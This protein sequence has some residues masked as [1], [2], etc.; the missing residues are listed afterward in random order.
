MIVGPTARMAF[1]KHSE[2]S[3]PVKPKLI[4]DW[5]IRQTAEIKEF[6]NTKQARADALDDR[7]T[8]ALKQEE[9]RGE[10]SSHEISDHKPEDSPKANC[11]VDY[12]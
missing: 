6:K 2:D 7:C 11:A 5:K 4:K 3:N 8:A 1:V 12:P 9:Q 10:D